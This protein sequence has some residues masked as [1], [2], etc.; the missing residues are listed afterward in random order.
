MFKVF[1]LVVLKDK[2]YEHYTIHLNKQSNDFRT[3]IIYN[4]SLSQ[5]EILNWKYSILI[6]LS[7]KH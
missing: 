7:N 5:I 2:V 6:N 1:N 3:C 4:L